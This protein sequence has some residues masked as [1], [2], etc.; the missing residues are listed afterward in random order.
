MLHFYYMEKIDANKSLVIQSKGL[1]NF[2]NLQ[3]GITDKLIKREAKDW[4]KKAKSYLKKGAYP[5][6]ID[7]CVKAIQI[8]PKDS[9]PYRYSAIARMLIGDYA[10]ALEDFE[11]AIE[12]NPLDLEIYLERGFMYYDLKKFHLA[13]KDF[14]KVIALDQNMLKLILVEDILIMI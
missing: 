11:L 5:E 12:C 8:T 4:L 13:I 9:T 7:A 6:A 2:T 1:V 3:L 10:D 14:T